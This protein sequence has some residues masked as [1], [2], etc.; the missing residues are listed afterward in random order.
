MKWGLQLIN[1]HRDPSLDITHF[2]AE[3]NPTTQE[4]RATYYYTPKC[5]RDSISVR[6][7]RD[8]EHFTYNGPLDQCEDAKKA[9]KN[10]GGTYCP[11]YKIQNIG[12]PRRESDLPGKCDDCIEK[13]KNSG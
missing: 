7:K 9:E 3:I 6:W 12:N 5:A 8:C 4:Q 10:G 1:F 13:E 11:E 2:A